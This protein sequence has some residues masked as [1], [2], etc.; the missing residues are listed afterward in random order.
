MTAT[1]DAIR[2]VEVRPP[3]ARDE[4]LSVVR[5]GM[6]VV[7]GAWMVLATDS[8]TFRNEEAGVRHLLPFQA[9]IRD[10]S[11]LEQRMFREL[12]EGLLEAEVSRVDQR[13]WPTPAALAADGI[14][15]FAVDPTAKGGPYNWQLLTSGLF[16]NYLGIPQRADVPAWLVLVQEPDPKGPPDPAREDEEHHRLFTGE[17]LHVSTWTR[18]DPRVPIRIVRTPQAEGW[19]QLY[20]VG[21]SLPQAPIAPPPAR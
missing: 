4:L 13:A 2:R 7:I 12:Q 11:P 20:A 16:V 10:R 18:G 19:T 15:P 6:L 14:P 9:L 3:S 1:A 5:V 21:P 8:A 17:M